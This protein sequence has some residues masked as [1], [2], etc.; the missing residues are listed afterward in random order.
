MR[1]TLVFASLAALL[2]A[3][4]LSGQVDARMFRYPDVSETQVTFVYAGDVWVAPKDGGT[5][6]RLSS[7]AGEETFPRFSPDGT[8][9]AFS[10]DYDGNVDVYVMPASGGMPT[11]LTWHPMAD[12]MVDWDPDGESL[13]YARNSSGPWRRNR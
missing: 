6:V 1:P 2:G 5:A 13:L 8:R 11:R 10:G 7:P 4:P 3:V 9:I 12:R